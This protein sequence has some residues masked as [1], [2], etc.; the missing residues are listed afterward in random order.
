MRGLE[1]ILKKKTERE[2]FK[3]IDKTEKTF[4]FPERGGLSARKEWWKSNAEVKELWS[5][6]DKPTRESG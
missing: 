5:C 1:N 4:I 2:D 6:T 3:T